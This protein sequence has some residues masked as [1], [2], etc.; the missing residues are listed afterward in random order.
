[1]SKRTLLWFVMAAGVIVLAALLHKT[2]GG[3]LLHDWLMR[4]HGR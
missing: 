3:G 2:D 1:M 4:L